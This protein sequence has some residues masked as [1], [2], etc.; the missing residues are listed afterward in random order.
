[1]NEWKNEVK[2]NEW[3]DEKGEGKKECIGEFR[4]REKW[5]SEWEQ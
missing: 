5:L 2:S 1:M 4:D 3:T